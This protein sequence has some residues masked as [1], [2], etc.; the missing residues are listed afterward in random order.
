MEGQ[1]KL[2]MFKQQKKL[3][4]ALG[5]PAV[6]SV[7][8]SRPSDKEE[9]YDPRS[10]HNL[11]SGARK[12]QLPGEMLSERLI[13]LRDGGG[14]DDKVLITGLKLYGIISSPS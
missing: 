7:A 13:A 9:E 8:H 3:S 1:N 10:R 12:V 2:S 4:L 6:I 14:S 11:C 5:I